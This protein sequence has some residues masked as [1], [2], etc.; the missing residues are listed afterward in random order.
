MASSMSAL[1]IEISSMMSS[2]SVRSIFTRSLR[3]ERFFS[4]IWYSVTSSL[5]SGRYGQRGSW[6]K[7][8]MV[9]PPALTAATPVGAT[10]ASLLLQPAT[11]CFRN[12]V[13]PVPAFPV[14]KTEIPVSCMYL[15]ASRK[16]LS[17]SILPLISVV[18][19]Q[20]RK[21]MI[22]CG[23]SKFF[24]EIFHSPRDND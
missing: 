12:V 13:F 1:T 22:V 19:F 24:R 6:K 16:R 5:T 7:E 9:T 14:R 23:K 18:I 11:M 4:G 15:S 3:R 10:T 20:H 8:W 17:F 2:S 21:I